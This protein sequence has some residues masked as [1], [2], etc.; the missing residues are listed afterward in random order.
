MKSNILRFFQQQK[1]MKFNGT[2]VDC[3]GGGG[4]WFELSTTHT[5]NDKKNL[6]PL[7]E[8]NSFIIC[9]DK[10]EKNEFHIFFDMNNKQT[11]KQTFHS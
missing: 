7:V 5:Q 2:V 11:N 8:G 4:I 9:D 3:A 1:K 10:Q 6:L